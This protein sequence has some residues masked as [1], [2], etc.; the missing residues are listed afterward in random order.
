MNIKNSFVDPDEDDDRYIKDIGLIQNVIIQR[1][2]QYSPDNHPKFLI[3]GNQAYYDKL[4]HLLSR[5]DSAP[6]L[7]E[8]TW[9]LLQ[10]IPVNA[11]LQ[12]EIK[13][14]SGV[15]ENARNWE[16]IL[17]P[18]STNKLLYSLKIINSLHAQKKDQKS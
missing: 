8:I 11:R 9:D 17:D 2:P 1:N 13:E 14:L 18:S 4:F 3:S 7:V 10:K 5:R 6:A 12:Q 15:M 16:R